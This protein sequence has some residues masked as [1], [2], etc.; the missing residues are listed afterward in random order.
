MDAEPAVAGPLHRLHERLATERTVAVLVGV[1]DD[2]P[3]AARPLDDD[4]MPA[5][6]PGLRRGSG[7]QYRI[8][9]IVLPRPVDRPRA[10][11]DHHVAGGRPVRASLGRHLVEVPAALEQLRALEAERLVV[12]VLRVR[13]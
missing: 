10:G 11:D 8:V 5:G 4:A 3:S 9:R 12:P 13:P 6:P 1:V 2:P 7:P